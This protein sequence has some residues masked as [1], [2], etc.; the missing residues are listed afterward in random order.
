[1][2]EMIKLI[3]THVKSKVHVKILKLS[4]QLC[5]RLVVKAYAVFITILSIEFIA[6]VLVDSS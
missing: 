6:F 1:M 2:D 3:N 4:C 5:K